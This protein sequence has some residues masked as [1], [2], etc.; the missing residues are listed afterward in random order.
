MI[1]FLF[2]SVVTRK[3]TLFWP[4]NYM[5]LFVSSHACVLTCLTMCMCEIEASAGL[6]I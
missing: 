4:Q 3:I 5:L 6:Y 2:Y 1:F